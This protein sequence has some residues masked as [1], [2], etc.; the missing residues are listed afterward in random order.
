MFQSSDT[1]YR[2]YNGLKITEIIRKLFSEEVDSEVGNM[3]EIQLE[4]GK[5]FECFADEIIFQ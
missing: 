3:Y 5:V 1:A 4:N 2:N